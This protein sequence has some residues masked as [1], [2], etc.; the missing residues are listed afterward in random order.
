M[1][2]YHR[3][4]H[5]KQARHRS[6]TKKAAPHYNEQRRR[7]QF[8]HWL[9]TPYK[10][11]FPMNQQQQQER[12]WFGASRAHHRPMPLYQHP[13]FVPKA[14]QPRLGSREHVLLGLQP[15]PP[16]LHQPYILHLSPTVN[17]LSITSQ[18]QTSNV[19]SEKQV[20]I[21]NHQ[22]E[23][24]KSQDYSAKSISNHEC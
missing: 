7:T 22:Y 6:E 21:D 19:K 8:D 9:Y 14:P 13:H 4:E 15:F 17:L 23:S 16:L 18:L 24:E 12:P 11:V 10:A 5:I 2:T 3:E 1:N 20:S